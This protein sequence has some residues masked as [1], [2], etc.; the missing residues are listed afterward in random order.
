MSDQFKSILSGN[1]PQDFL[2][3]KEQP[4]IPFPPA[5]TATLVATSKCPTCGAP[6][7][8]PQ[9]IMI[10]VK[11]PQANVPVMFSCECRLKK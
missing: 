6:I 9:G 1:P 7:Y 4:G 11:N 5:G 8:S 3:T 2:R 10:E